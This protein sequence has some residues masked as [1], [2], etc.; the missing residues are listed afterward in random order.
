MVALPVAAV[1][2]VEQGGAGEGAAGMLLDES[3]PRHLRADAAAGL[4]D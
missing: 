2:E 1:G 3:G 4:F